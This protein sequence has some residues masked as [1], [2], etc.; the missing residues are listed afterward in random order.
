[1]VCA[2]GKNSG[3]SESSGGDN[4]GVNIV[5]DSDAE[6]FKFSFDGTDGYVVRGYV[7]SSEYIQIPSSY[8][9]SRGVLPVKSIGYAAFYLSNDDSN[10]G[11][12]SAVKLKGVVIPDTITEIGENAFMLNSELKEIVVPDSVKKI[13]KGAFNGCSS[14]QKISLPFVGETATTTENGYIGYIFSATNWENNELYVPRSLEEIVITGG[15]YIE[16]GGL[17]FCRNVKSIVL[18]STLVSI[19]KHGLWYAENVESL[20]IPDSVTELGD[21]CL[22]GLSKL[23]DL[24][25]PFLGSSFGTYSDAYIGYIFGATKAQENARYMPSTLKNVLLTRQTKLISGAFYGL[26]GLESVT[27]P[28]TLKTVADDAFSGCTSLNLNE[29]DG[30]GYLGSEDN[31]YLLAM[32]ADKNLSTAEIQSGCIAIMDGAF[33]LC[34]NLTS[35]KIPDGVSLIGQNAFYR[36]SSLRSID[37]PDSVTSIG[38]AAFYGATSLES[39]NMNNS[40]NIASIGSAAFYDCENLKQFTISAGITSIGENAFLGCHSLS[41]VDIYGLKE[42]LGISFSNVFSSPFKN[43]TEIFV[44]GE[45]V[46]KI[47]VPETVKK[48]GKFAFANLNAVNEITLSSAVTRVETWAFYGMGEGLK[49]NFPKAKTSYTLYVDWDYGCEAEVV[50]NYVG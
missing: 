46:D 17:A 32:S 18:P 47:V 38:S 24:T 31:H 50:F 22:N 45:K 29:K 42:Y 8:E 16:E 11:E 43:A 23:K 19:G 34:K 48:I 28:S 36:S 26:S 33:S 13:G 27:L 6:H 40:S 20:V 25:L 5:Y 15:K 7:G 39:V 30:V 1:M 35:V 49:I 2:C 44:G 14:L 41:R 12:E 3:E 37:I 21:S 4:A 9:G 10:D